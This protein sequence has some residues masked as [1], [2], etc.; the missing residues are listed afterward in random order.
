MS[1]EEGFFWWAFGAGVVDFDGDGFGFAG[2]FRLER[3]QV[4][5]E[6]DFVAVAHGDGC[7]G[8]GGDCPAVVF[9][10]GVGLCCDVS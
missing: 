2:G 6:L 8:D 10:D 5:G 9:L 4:K 3:C 1:E 7:L